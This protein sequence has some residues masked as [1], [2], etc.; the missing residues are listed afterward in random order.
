MW[1]NQDINV[2]KHVQSIAIQHTSQ[3]VNLKSELVRTEAVE[4]NEQNK[5]KNWTVENDATKQKLEEVFM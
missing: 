1:K 2:S 5:I 4:I 3:Y